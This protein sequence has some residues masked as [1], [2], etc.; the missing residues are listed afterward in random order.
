LK[1]AP[2]IFEDVGEMGLILGIN[3]EEKNIVF[4][5]VDGGSRSG[6]KIPRHALED[7]GLTSNW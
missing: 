1:R 7:F 4:F 6:L 3:V 5:L 2:T